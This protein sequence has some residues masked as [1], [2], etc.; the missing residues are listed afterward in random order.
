LSKVISATLVGIQPENWEE[1]IRMVCGPLLD[2]EAITATYIDRCIEMVKEHGPYMVIAPGI[3]LA[4]ARPE[5]GVLALCLSV[6][7][8]ITPVPFNH[9]ENDP[10]DILFAF[11]SPDKKQHIN[12]L[13]ALASALSSGLADELRKAENDEEAQGILDEVLKEVVS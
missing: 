6:A 4:H 12:L 11:G 13:S 10:V 9:P 2:Q 8:L 7:T 3:A 1:S 5:D